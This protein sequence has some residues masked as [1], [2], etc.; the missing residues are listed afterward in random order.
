MIRKSLMVLFISILLLFTACSGGEESKPDGNI[1]VAGKY[2][3]VGYLPSWS[4]NWFSE[5]NYQDSQLVNVDPLFTHVVISFVK[6]DLVFDENSNTFTGTGIQFSSNFDHV[7]LA[8]KALKNKGVKV[9]LAIG[10]ATYNEWSAI[11]K[12][13]GKSIATTVHKKAL[14]SLIRALDVDGLD[15]D[16]EISGVDQNNVEQ[17]YNSII[18]LHEV[19]SETYTILTIAGWSTGADCTDLTKT[20]TY[21]QNKLSFWGGNAGRERLVFNKLN[22]NG[23][24]VNKLFN[25]VSIMSYDGS[26]KRFDPVDLYQSYQS[27]YAGK[28]AIGFE[29]AS[30]AWGGAELVSTNS[31]AMQCEGTDKSS[32]IEGN[33]YEVYENKK[34][35]S[36]ERFVKYIK[37]QENSGIMLWSLYKAEGTKPNCTYALDNQGFNDSVRKFLNIITTIPGDGN[38]T[39]PGDGNITVPG[40]GNI[41]VPGDNYEIPSNEVN[42]LSG[43]EQNIVMEGTG[44]VITLTYKKDS[45]INFRDAKI[46]LQGEAEYIPNIDATGQLSWINPT[47][48]YEKTKSSILTILKF[49]TFV[50]AD[51]V[52]TIFD[53]L[54]SK[55]IIKFWPTQVTDIK[56]IKVIHITPG[57]ETNVIELKEES[58]PNRDDAIS[59]RVKGWPSTLAMGSVTDNN[60]GLNSKFYESKIDSVFKYEGD[61]FGD[62][63]DVIEPIVTM[64]TIRQAREIEALDTTGKIRIMPT[65]VIYTAN[66][67]GGG[68]APNDIKEN[69]KTVNS[70][71]YDNNTNIN[72]SNL[73][74]H[75]RNTIRMAAQMQVNKDFKHPYPATI[76]LDADLFGEWQKNKLNGSFQEEYCGGSSDK[77]CAA[78]Q[79]IK[80]R[81]AMLAAIEL[82]KNYDV[83]KY[84][85]NAVVSEGTKTVSV[86]SLS[87]QYS[88]NEIKSRIN[89]S[90]I[91]N[92]IKGWVQ[93]QN[94]MIK[95]FAPDVP[96]G[97]VI[98][99]WNPGSAHWVHKQYS[100][101]KDIWL[102]ASKS[103]A[104]FVEWIGAYEKNEYRP[105]FLTFDKYERDGFSAAGKPSYAFSSRA[106]DNYLM[107]AKQ[108]T[109]FIDIPAMLWQIPGGHMAT[110]NEKSAGEHR[111]CGDSSDNSGCF[112]HLDTATNGGHSATGGSYFM[113]DKNIGTDISNIR[114]DVLDISISGTHYNGA[115]NVRELIQQTDYDLTYDWGK[116]QLRHA[117]FSNAFAI[118]WGGGE[119]TGAVPIST[120]LTGGY[121]WLKDK[122]VAYN[123]DGRIPLYYKE[124]LSGSSKELTSVLSL[125]KEL[126]SGTMVNTMNTEVLLFN[127]GTQW[128][129]STIYKWEDFLTALNAMHNKGVAGD[130]FWLY[131]EDGSTD[132]QKSNYA[133]VAMASFLAQ[134]MQE[135]IQYDACDE[136]SWQFIKD[137]TATHPAVLASYKRGDFSVDL[138]LDAAC[139]QLGQVYADYGVDKNGVDNPYSCPKTPKM[140]V[141]AVTNARYYG[142][143]GPLFSA[144]NKVLNDLGLLVN[145]KSGRWDY[146]Q[147]CNGTPAF[148]DANFSDP[149][150]D[151]WLREECKVYK[152]QKAG[153][154]V[155]DG[156]SK[157]DLQG[158]SWWGRGVIQTTGRENFGKLN[159][160]LGRSHIDKSLI[161]KDVAWAG[162]NIK[163][164]PAPENPLYADMDLCSNPELI[165]SSKKNKEIKWIAGLFF[166]VNSVQAY[167]ME[168]GK[169]KDWNYYIELKKYVDSDFGKTN[170]KPLNGISFIDSIS[171]IVNRGCP[172]NTCPVSGEVH[173]AKDRANNFKKVLLGLGIK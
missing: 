5:K 22:A 173:G 26:F 141:T 94:F 43:F 14:V 67:S 149:K 87:S 65:L 81:E 120:N 131:D 128:I 82:E 7:K 95:E 119:T 79:T 9:T 117:A 125:N 155:W 132:E 118:L 161:G 130:K 40:D 150:T 102:N 163:I 160:F 116:S 167:N 86:G 109:D 39:V 148:S 127:T 91:E 72:E 37:T 115:K 15:V 80:V 30:E 58:K 84:D 134:S 59:L 57:K 83:K 41:T 33:S 172:D 112:R 136:N 75:F 36:V 145:G 140:E 90:N 105:D 146:Q 51:Y 25:Y 166:W 110:V 53:G 144:P 170:Y 8:I 56:N 19:A 47:E 121:A 27:I 111:L 85:A 16:Y 49:D 133:K 29:L 147:H 48:K 126:E 96:F 60:F 42:V 108:I 139:G 66:G 13:K 142:A 164:K 156:S 1:T 98:N 138:P 99:L 44:V 55:L 64:Q 31:E 17:Y 78:Y 4:V 20:D 165:C 162:T 62:R 100:G 129:P 50:Q 157:R 97:W 46:Y 114:T 151:G 154:V 93:S 158:C 89:E 38:I 6:P 21:C 77:D 23:Y 63:G 101:E 104:L 28:L 76:V 34:P 171:G 137:A 45:A 143:S 70:I 159:H 123:E 92:N 152:G 10:G 107:F 69:Y 11:A 88:L 52:D 3:A 135:T 71:D 32:M 24:D 68:L 124:E 73:V 54:N 153:L 74:K 168:Q 2:F 61:G 106:W 122:I 35:Y 18:S 103:V 169:Y 12:E 113:G